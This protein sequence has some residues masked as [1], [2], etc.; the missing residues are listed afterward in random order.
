MYK[1]VLITLF[2]CTYGCFGSLEDADQALEKVMSR[3]AKMVE[4]SK[5]KDRI[6]CELNKLGD[7]MEEIVA[8]SMSKFKD[9]DKILERIS[10][11]ENE[12]SAEIRELN[13]FN[14]MEHGHTEDM[15]AHPVITFN[16][17]FK[18]T[19]EVLNDNLI[20]YYTDQ[21][22]IEH[23][24]EYMEYH[25]NVAYHPRFTMDLVP[26][27]DDMYTNERVYFIHDKNFAEILSN[28]YPRDKNSLY[29]YAYNSHIGA[30][31]DEVKSEL[32]RDA[33]Y[34]VDN[35]SRNQ[36]RLIDFR[37]ER[38]QDY[39]E[40]AIAY[41]LHN[42]DA[43]KVQDITKDFIIDILNIFKNHEQYAERHNQY[44]KC[45]PNYRTTNDYSFY[46][47]QFQNS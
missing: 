32:I 35:L 14:K 22:A 9:K 6:S 5:E 20:P 36:K 43:F 17:L 7:E 34:D 44:E 29:G 38:L 39:I 19:S 13:K 16:N 12:L 27:F 2:V 45:I 42:D 30:L 23:M 25:R 4:L 1:K 37:W 26:I 21:E 15:Y 28:P 47:N 40:G 10:A 3:M 24:E 41:H 46:L 11:I 8:S 18:V 33:G 31:L